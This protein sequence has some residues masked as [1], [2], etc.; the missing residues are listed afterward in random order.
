MNPSQ[1]KRFDI[2]Y[3]QHVKA[4]KRQGKAKATIDAYSRAVRRIAE[5]FDR[6][7]ERL[8]VANLKDYFSSL[9]QSHS[10]STIKLDRNGLQF[11][12]RHVLNK[13]WDW[14]DIVKPPQ[15]RSLPDILTP[16]ELALVI[17]SARELRYQVYILTAYSMGLRL[18]E[19]LNLKV[20]D[21]DAKQ[22]RVHIRNGK[23]RKDRYVTLPEL[24]LYAL[25]KYWSTHKNRAWLFPEGRNAE[26]RCQAARPMSRGG[27][28][29]SFKVI[30]LDC[31]IHKAITIHS[32]RHCYGA[33][34]M[35]AGV[36]LRAIQ[37]E[38]GHD[39]PKTTAVYTQLTEPAAQNANRMINEL[40]NALDLRFVEA[41]A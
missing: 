22:H 17:N 16:D 28:Q 23:G 36:H 31:N 10:W 9:V 26:Q 13:Q 3:Q 2:L 29:K 1:Q 20:G 24:T 38:M 33:H 8:S 37:Q 18:G 35:A 30:V 40:V 21:I 12:Y 25:R 7:P 39:S 27:S 4:L 41:E 6:C 11:F 14:I 32:L 19:A 15:V 5:Y 34:L